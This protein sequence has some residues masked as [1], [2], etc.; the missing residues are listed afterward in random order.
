[1]VRANGSSSNRGC[2]TRPQRSPGIVTR[3]YNDGIA[4]RVSPCVRRS[5][6][7][8]SRFVYGASQT[9]FMPASRTVVRTPTVIDHRRDGVDRPPGDRE[10]Y[11]LALNILNV[12]MEPRYAP[13][14]LEPVKCFRGQCSSFAARHHIEF[15]REYLRPLPSEGGAVATATIIAWIEQRRRAAVELADA[16]SYL[17]AQSA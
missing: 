10:L 16:E 4:R 8:R 7:R 3:V 11:D 12:S 14:R 13:R 17:E 6:T 15:A 9:S 5:D 1:M 2:V